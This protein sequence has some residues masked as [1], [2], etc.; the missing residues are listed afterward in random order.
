MRPNLYKVFR[1]FALIGAIA[2]PTLASA[3]GVNPVKA[4]EPVF[5][6][7]A[8]TSPLSTA[9]I[10]SDAK[11]GT[12][13]LV[14]RSVSASQAKAIALKRVKGGEVVDISRNGGVYRVRLIRNDGRVVDV[15]V[16]AQTGR[17][18]N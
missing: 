2:L 11:P 6:G 13:L 15:F 7:L 5:E 8:H 4:S 16:D 3:E 18:K 1:A 10:F 17:V 9:V 12:D 14:Q